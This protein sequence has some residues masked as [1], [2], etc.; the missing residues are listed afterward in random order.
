MV[1]SIGRVAKQ[2]GGAIN[3]G[4]HALGKGLDK[5]AHTVGD[6]AAKYAPKAANIA[7]KTADFLES[8]IG[9]K[10]TDTAATVAENVGIPGGGAIGKGLRNAGRAARAAAGALSNTNVAAKIANSNIGTL[11][12]R[13]RDAGAS[14]SS[15]ITNAGS[16][17]ERRLSS[18]TNAFLSN[19]AGGGSMNVPGRG[20][21]GVQIGRAAKRLA[22]GLSMPR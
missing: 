4:A 18:S 11:G 20:G 13:V 5:A 7:N 16:A 9:S 8:E 19:A 12:K 1:F 22:T 6:I 3:R 2:F 10:V 15:A 14:A 21:I 17:A